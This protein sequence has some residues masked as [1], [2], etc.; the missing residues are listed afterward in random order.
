LDAFLERAEGLGATYEKL[1]V[2]ALMERFGDRRHHEELVRIAHDLGV[3]RLPMFPI[4]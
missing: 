4:S 3:I 2:I 1:V